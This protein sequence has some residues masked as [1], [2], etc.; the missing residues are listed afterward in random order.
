MMCALSSL[1]KRDFY[2]DWNNRLLGNFGSI[3]IQNS[4]VPLRIDRWLTRSFA[5]VILECEQY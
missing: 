4:D 5:V 1:S 3:C 2:A